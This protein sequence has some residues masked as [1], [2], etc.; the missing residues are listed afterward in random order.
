M[1]TSIIWAD[2]SFAKLPKPT[3]GSIDRRGENLLQRAIW[4]RWWKAELN[5]N[6]LKSSYC[7]QE[8]ECACSIGFPVIK[9]IYP[10]E[11]WKINVVIVQYEQLVFI[12]CL[13]K[14]KRIPRKLNYTMCTKKMIILWYKKLI[15]LGKIMKFDLL[16]FVLVTLESSCLVLTIIISYLWQSSIIFSTFPSRI[17]KP[18]HVSDIFSNLSKGFG[19]IVLPY[20]IA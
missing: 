20:Q 12:E 8:E 6:G 9:G 17:I 2:M 19:N 18:P 15:S 13:K 14:K 7:G 5:C 4:V 10:I 16:L 1:N 11:K 3:G